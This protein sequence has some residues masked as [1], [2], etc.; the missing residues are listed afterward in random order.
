MIGKEKVL[1]EMIAMEERCYGVQRDI[2][3][4]MTQF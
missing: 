4:E 3:A 2:Y 1:V